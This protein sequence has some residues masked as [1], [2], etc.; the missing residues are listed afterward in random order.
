MGNITR[1]VSFK[2]FD[3]K[4]QIAYGEVYVPNEKDTD[5]NWMT[6]ETIEKMAHDFMAE[7]RLTQIDTN[8]DGNT[9][10]GV[11]V[12]S[13][14]A[15]KGDPDFAEGAWAVGVKVSDKDTW[16]A[17]EKGEITGFS[18][19]GRGDLIVETGEKGD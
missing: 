3:A 11:I 10:K 1:D 6:P 15:R 17:I 12:E 13:F 14:I 5:G 8:H 18:V 7:Q 19:E 4:K 16:K 2:K 9:D